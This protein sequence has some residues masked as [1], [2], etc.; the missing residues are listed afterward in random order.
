[1]KQVKS[2]AR[3]CDSTGEGLQGD[4]HLVFA[5]SE[6][7]Q[8]APPGRE[9]GRS[10]ERE[11]DLQQVNLYKYKI[12]PEIVKSIPFSVARRHQVVPIEKRGEKITLAMADPLNIVAIDEVSYLTGAEVEP[13]LASREEIAEII[14]WYYGVRE[15]VEKVTRIFP[16]DEGITAED[17]NM[18]PGELKGMA[19]EA[20]VVQ[21][22][23]SLFQQATRE[24]ASDIHLEVQE[25]NVKIRYR[26]DGVLLE[27]LTLPKN[28]YAPLL[29]RIKIMAG[30]D[31]AEKRL[32]QDGRI[33][34]QL[35]DREV[36]MRVSTL[37]TITGE[38]V[39]IRLLDKKSLYWGL[40]ELGFSQSNLDTFKN[41][42]HRSHGLILVTGPTGAGKTTTLYAA[43]QELD[44][45]SQ[46]IIT[47]E[48]PVEYRLEGI[49]QVQIN[50]RAGLTFARGLRSILRQDPN[51]IMVGEIRDRET[52]DIAVRAALTGHLVL[53]T[54]HTN[55]G[56]GALT[57]L[58]DMGIEPYL[59]ASAVIGIVAQRLVRVLCPYCRIP[60]EIPSGARVRET[61]GIG[62][63]EPLTLYGPSGCSYCNYT[64]YRGRTAITEVLVMSRELE[65]LVLEKAPREA[66]HTAAWKAGMLSLWEDGYARVR[67]GTTTLQEVMRVIS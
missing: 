23:N 20:P 63:E 16:E 5:G 12:A 7:N 57:R 51:I 65:K 58:L 34:I 36:D 25:N 61:L 47:I 22:V 41:M 54:L 30:M 3:R 60:E 18:T 1:M 55:D 62:P 59:V 6:L 38:K 33:Q 31:I 29:T 39:V 67:Q 4:I 13:V 49:N 37:P 26:I 14:S 66:I 52:V 17:I 45:A 8:A 48:D 11:P 53:S 43:L 64:G 9:G 44:T 35:D 50:N 27:A 19:E 40:D 32:P 2:S 15:Q 46:N 28:I 24:R 21:A 56:A 10:Q 42:I